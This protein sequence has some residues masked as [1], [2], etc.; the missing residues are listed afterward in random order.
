MAFFSL[1]KTFLVTRYGFQ[2]TSP[3]SVVILICR[4]FEEGRFSTFVCHTHSTHYDQCLVV[5]T[6][7]TTTEVQYWDLPADKETEKA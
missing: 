4:K 1:T 2:Y 7:A 3:T 5:V 6:N